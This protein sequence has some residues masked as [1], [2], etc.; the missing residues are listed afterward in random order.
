MIVGRPARG[1][2]LGGPA[3]ALAFFVLAFAVLA[4][5]PGRAEAYVRYKT[6]TGKPFYWPQ[7]CV[8]VSAYPYSMTDVNGHMEMTPDEIMH[9]ATAA[10]DA[11]STAEETNG[12]PT[13]A[14]GA[15]CTFLR[16]NVT[17]SDGPT[18]TARFDY[19]NNIIFRT[20][21]W[22][23]PTDGPGMCTYDASA[24]AITSVFVDK[25]TGEIRDGD[26]EVNAKGFIWADLDINTSPQNQDLQNALTHEMGHLIGLDHTCYI[27]DL[28][29][30]DPLDNNGNPVPD[31]EAADATVRAT[32]MFASAIP[33]DTEKRTLAPDDIQ[34][35]CDIYPIADDPKR[36]PVEDGPPASCRCGV[37]GRAPGAAAT[38]VAA[39]ALV[40]ALGR[41]RRARRP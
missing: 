17:E 25:N 35:V 36:C 15:V 19:R 5:A 6:D 34:A 20:L 10:S 27:A 2:G 30:P 12:V 33:G 28:G 11:W 37:G 7:S 14:G 9:A 3:L 18:P 39:V 23:A 38:V 1:R 32:T 29:A 13:D 41:R 40:F 16:I 31:C 4:L 24:L 21:S 8:P 26:I 22:C